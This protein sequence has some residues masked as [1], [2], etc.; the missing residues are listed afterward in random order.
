MATG[1]S[2]L[3][4]LRTLCYIV[5]VSKITA[6]AQKA[7]QLADDVW[8]LAK[9]LEPGRRLSVS[10]GVRELKSVSTEIHNQASK[11]ERLR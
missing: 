1:R 2:K 3:D 11:L 7:R 10:D 8:E 6:L 9:E 5:G 4:T